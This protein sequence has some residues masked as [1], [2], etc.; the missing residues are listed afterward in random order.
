M[1]T[2]RRSSRHVDPL[3][4]EPSAKRPKKVVDSDEDEL[5]T[6]EEEDEP[7]EEEEE[8][9]AEEEQVK[10]DNKKI[11]LAEYCYGLMEQVNEE[12]L[13]PAEVELDEFKAAWT[14][15]RD[16]E[17][18]I[19]AFGDEHSPLSMDEIHEGVRANAM[20]VHDWY[21][22]IATVGGYMEAPYRKEAIRRHQISNLA[23]LPDGL[24]YYGDEEE[25]GSGVREGE[26][27]LGE[28]D[29][30]EEGKGKQAQKEGVKAQAEPKKKFFNRLKTARG[31]Y[32]GAGPRTEDVDPLEPW[33]SWRYPSEC[34]G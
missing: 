27:E 18:F 5:A 17:P 33:N 26:D 20:T 34:G 16:G 12:D 4:G 28:E 6:E 14:K 11:F 30:A 2:R 7:E 8:Q 15:L 25:A 19:H 9:A 3:E 13:L 24:Q 22:I 32:V 21:I 23:L 31:K 10:G 29:E 1:A